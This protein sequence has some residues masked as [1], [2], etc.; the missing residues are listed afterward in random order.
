M[1]RQSTRFGFVVLHYLVDAT[2]MQCV[3]SIHEHC[4]GSDYHIVVVD[5]DSANGSFERLQARYA[6]TPGVT[7]LHNT[8]NEGFARGN[9]VGYR[10]CKSQLH[11]DYIVTINNDAML[12]SADFM[13]LCTEDYAQMH[14]GVIGPDIVSLKDGRH[15]NPSY[16]IIRTRSE[17]NR[18]IRRFRAILLLLHLHLYEPLVRLKQRLGHQSAADSPYTH[19][20]AEADANRPYKLHG[21]CMIFT[22][23]FVQHYD[24]PFDPRTFLYFEEHILWMRCQTAGL[25]MHYDPRIVVKHVEDASTDSMSATTRRKMIFTLGNYVRSLKVLGTYTH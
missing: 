18:Q 5:N 24:E 16:G 10:Y 8:A 13:P 22:P 9:N 12:T 15:Q 25:T 6:E 3:E 11:C 4:A 17:V 20:T 21:A 1:S 14:C 2:T 7:L 19:A 23:A